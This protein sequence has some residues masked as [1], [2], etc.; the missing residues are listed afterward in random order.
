M[1]HRKSLLGFR[2]ACEQMWGAQGLEDVRRTLAVEHVKSGRFSIEEIAY[3]L[4]YS[5]LANFRRAFRRWESVPPSAYRASQVGKSEVAPV[6]G[7]R[8]GS[9]GGRGD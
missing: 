6:A 1:V 5:D 7:S 9:G 2:A 3:M 8:G 4:G